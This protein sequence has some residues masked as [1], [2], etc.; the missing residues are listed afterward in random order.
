MCN[1]PIKCDRPK[2][3]N[4]DYCSTHNKALGIKVEKEK[5]VY[6]IPKV[7]NNEKERKKELAKMYP[8]YLSEPG[9]EFCQLKLKGCLGKASTVH[10]LRGRI[11]DQ[12]FEINDWMPSC[13]WC[14]ILVENDPEAYQKELKKSKFHE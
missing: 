7:S 6:Q 1:W 12:V 3:G 14:N 9:N 10:H 8:V 2:Q 11:G 4:T 5:K 13:S